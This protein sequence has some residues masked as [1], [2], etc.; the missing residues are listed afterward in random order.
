MCVL[1]DPYNQIKD[2]PLYIYKCCPDVAPTTIAGLNFTISL[3]SWATCEP[4]GSFD[5]RCE[6]VTLM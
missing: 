3:A 1:V 4:G 2:R 5:A 6:S